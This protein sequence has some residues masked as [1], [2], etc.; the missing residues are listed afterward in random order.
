M[1][2]TLQTLVSD[3]HDYWNSHTLG[4]QYVTDAALEVGSPEYFDH[5]RPFYPEKLESYP[6]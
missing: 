3:V 6:V 5:I 2:E 4:Y 1:D